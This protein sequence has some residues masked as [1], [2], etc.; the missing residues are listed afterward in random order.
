MIRCFVVAMCGSG[1]PWNMIYDIYFNIIYLYYVQNNE[2]STP[3]E[4]HI[5]KHTMWYG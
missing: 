3:A 2:N 1:D 5:H 4:F